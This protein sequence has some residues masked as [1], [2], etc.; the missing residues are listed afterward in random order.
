MAA[1]IT[2]FRDLY[3]RVENCPLPTIAKVDGA[4]HGGG[5]EL[6]MA[7]DIWVASLA[8]GIKQAEINLGLILCLTGRELTAG[9]AHDY[10]VFL[11][12]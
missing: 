6:A 1:Y 7:C 9:E 8:V 2:A 10:G 3:N 12:C 5:S 11:R 4:A